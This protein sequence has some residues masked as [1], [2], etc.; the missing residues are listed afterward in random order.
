MNV[1]N[2][3]T[4]YKYIYNLIQTNLWASKLLEHLCTVI[5]SAKLIKAWIKLN[6]SLFLGLLK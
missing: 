1:Q 6:C 5:K 3:T 4:K 2:I